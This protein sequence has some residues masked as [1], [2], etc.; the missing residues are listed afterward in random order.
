MDAET[1]QPHVCLEKP[2]GKSYEPP[3]ESLADRM[4][5]LEKRVAILERICASK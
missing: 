1:E 4:D 2:R 5:K 3:A